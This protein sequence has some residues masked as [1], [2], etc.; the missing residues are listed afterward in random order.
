MKTRYKIPIIVIVGFL[1]FWIFT[2]TIA[3]HSCNAL[4]IDWKTN[5]FCNVNGELINQTFV[6]DPNLSSNP[7]IRL[8]DQMTQPKTC[9]DDKNDKSLPSCDEVGQ[10]FQ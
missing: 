5:W 9:T 3:L 7:T 1:V 8:I 10:G 6:W 4:E 2:P